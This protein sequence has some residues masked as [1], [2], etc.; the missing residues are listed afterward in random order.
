MRRGEPLPHFDVQIP[1]PSLP[2]VFG[3]TLESI[4]AQVP[5]LTADPQRRAYWRDRL[6][7]HNAV[8]EAR[9]TQLDGSC[10]P[11]SAPCALQKVGLVWAGRPKEDEPHNPACPLE[12]FRPLAQVPGVALYSLQKGEAARQA[13]QISPD[14]GLIDW[15]AE[16]HDF[17]DTAALMGQMDL[18]ISVDTS[19]AHLA[20]ALGKP[21]WLMLPLLP[22]FRWLLWRED[23][24]WYPTMRL[25]RQK[26]LGDWDEVFQ[27]IVQALRKL[28]KDEG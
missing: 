15:T 5:Y 18:V 17:A 4:P 6:A 12:K 11:R 25:F 26:H 23:S 9:N 24:P 2:L 7:T 13:R 3:T 8:Y 10:A 21:V 14:M 1:L 27:R 28:R 22:D 16:L 20:G 19:M